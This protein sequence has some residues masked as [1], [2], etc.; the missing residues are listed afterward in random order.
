MAAPSPW[1]VCAHLPDFFDAL[2]LGLFSHPAG[3]HLPARAGLLE[4]SSLP[5]LKHCVSAFFKISCFFL[6]FISLGEDICTC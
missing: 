1:L 3:E 5:A 2:K 6:V 4:T